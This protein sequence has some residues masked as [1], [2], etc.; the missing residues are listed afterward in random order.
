M[1]DTEASVARSGLLGRCPRCGRGALF[2]KLLHIR[3]AC[4]HCGL[5][6]RTADTGDGPAIFAIFIL[7]F[8]VLGGALWVEFRLEPPLWVHVTLWGLLTPI[9]ALGLLRVLKGT[10]FALQYR[11]KA[12]EGRIDTR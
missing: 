3:Q 9:L 7:G 6:Y 10:L 2:S 5:D 8:L 4:P 12:A 1:P 11:N